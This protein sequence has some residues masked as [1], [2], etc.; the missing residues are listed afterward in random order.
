MVYGLAGL[1]CKGVESHCIY[2]G[3]FLFE[4]GR[5]PGVYIWTWL[6]MIT[7]TDHKEIVAHMG[8]KMV[9]Q[10]NNMSDALTY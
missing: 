5:E 7:N 1:T 3:Y 10:H 8:E 4:R 2:Y 9:Y 6:A